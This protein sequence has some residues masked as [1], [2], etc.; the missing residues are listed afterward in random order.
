MRCFILL[1][2]KTASKITVRN[3]TNLIRGYGWDGA[4]GRDET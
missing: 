3:F 1:F 4:W 2:F